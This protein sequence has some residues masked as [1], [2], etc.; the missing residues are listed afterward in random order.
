MLLLI[1]IA[2][3]VLTFV[4]MPMWGLHRFGWSP[5]I[6]LGVALTLALLYVLMRQP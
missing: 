3:I 2:V 5:V 6:V 1:A 4:A